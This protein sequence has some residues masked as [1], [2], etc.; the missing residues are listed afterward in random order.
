MYLNKS[1]ERTG[2][3]CQNFFRT[4][5]FNQKLATILSQSIQERDV[6]LGK[7]SSFVSFMFALFPSLFPPQALWQSQK[8]AA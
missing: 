1:N 7:K 6:N 4:Q 5:L 2:K 3:S 8:P